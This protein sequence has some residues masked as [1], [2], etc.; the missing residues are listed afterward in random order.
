MSKNPPF[1]V[2]VPFL[3]EDAGAAGA[4]AALQI[5]Y[6]PLTGLRAST[7]NARRHAERQL[8]KL[9]ASIKRYGFLVPV[10]IDSKGEIIAGEARVEAARRAGLAEVPTICV[11]RLTDA[12][13]REFR[14]A[15][16][17]LHDLSS[18]DQKALAIEI[19]EILMIDAD[20]FEAMGFDTAEIDVL[21]ESVVIDGA[22]E[23]DPADEVP[24]PPVIPVSQLGDLWRLGK[25]RLLCGS[26][27]EDEAWRI[28]MNGQ[29]ATM[30][31][32]DSPYNVKIDKHV[33]GLG[34]VQHDEFVMASGEMSAA[35]FTDFLAGFMRPMADHL[36]KG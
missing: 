2:A 17:K 16:N 21:L 4:G 28:L 7:R 26:S 15:E 3:D 36:C 29:V 25:H 9:A 6:R 8:V 31:F 32:T 24:E 1:D 12:Q 33:C 10:L 34:K 14:I 5:V 18:F 11:D 35:E 22:E 30:G 19:G 27:L 13:I 23:I 20:G